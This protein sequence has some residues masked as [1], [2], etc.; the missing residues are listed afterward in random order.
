M[1]VISQIELDK[2]QLYL[3]KQ[4]QKLYKVIIMV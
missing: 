3:E 2:E 4:N 1:K